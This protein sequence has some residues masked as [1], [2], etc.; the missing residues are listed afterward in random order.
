MPI[1]KATFRGP[2]P[3]NLPA[4]DLLRRHIHVAGLK[5]IQLA[6]VLGVQP[7]A[8]HRMFQRKHRPILPRQL[9]A[10]IAHLQLDEFDANELRLLAAAREAGWLID[11]H[12]LLE[13]Q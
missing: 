9:E 11:P 8:V 7:L 1:P 5:L 6:P 13:D 3:R 4:K 10:L 12:Y 2:V